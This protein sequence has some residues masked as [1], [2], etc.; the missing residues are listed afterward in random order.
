M[1]ENFG[2]TGLDLELMRMAKNA[3]IPKGEK[4]EEVRQWARN[5]GIKKIGIAYCASTQKEAEA[6]QAKLSDE[7]EVIMAGCKIGKIPLADILG[8]DVPGLACNPIGQAKFL[9]EAG[10]EMVLVIGLCL[11]H[12]MIF[13]RHCKLPMSVFIVKDRAH[14]H[15]PMASLFPPQ[16]PE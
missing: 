2:Y 10:C 11:G 7:F 16:Q 14:K 5:A 9:E 3:T 12:D 4:L 8:E 6:V 13:Q 1:E 15:N